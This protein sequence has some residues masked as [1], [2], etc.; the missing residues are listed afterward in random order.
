M[1]ASIT[2]LLLYNQPLRVV[3]SPKN[4]NQSIKMSF[5]STLIPQ[6]WINL[7]INL[8]FCLNAVNSP[9]IKR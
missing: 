3:Q 7:K 9:I 6:R 5:F 8:I 1:N 2:S 4:C